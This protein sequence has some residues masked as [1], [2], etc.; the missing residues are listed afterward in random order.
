M[1][2]DLD[3]YSPPRT[4]EAKDLF[5][6]YA[7]EGGD[8]NREVDSLVGLAINRLSGWGEE[9]TLVRDDYFTEY[10]ED[11]TKGLIEIPDFI[12]PYINWQALADAMLTDYIPVEINTTTYYVRG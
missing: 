12:A 4:I 3:L 7:A 8:T 5:A 10:A 1:T 6:L 11:Y 2:V 9:R